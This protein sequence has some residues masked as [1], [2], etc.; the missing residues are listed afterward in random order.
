ML[1]MLRF[2]LVAGCGCCSTPSGA[3]AKD[4]IKQSA[5]LGRTGS[6][7]SESGVLGLVVVPET[8]LALMSMQVLLSAATTNRDFGL[9]PS[10]VTYRQTVISRKLISSEKSVPVLINL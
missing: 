6:E 2:I 4:D 5:F 10:P 8:R 3:P 1:L 7:A 9:P